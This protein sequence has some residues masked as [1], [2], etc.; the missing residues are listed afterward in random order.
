MRSGTTKSGFHFEIKKEALDD[1]ELLEVLAQIDAGDTSKLPEMIDRLLGTEQKCV[2][3]EHVRKLSKEGRVSAEKMFTE[4][5]D[6]FE[7]CKEV[8]N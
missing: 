6:I 3:K 7:Q 8:K 2:L 1:Y 4:V 5:A